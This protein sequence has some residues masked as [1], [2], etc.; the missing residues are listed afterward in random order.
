[1]SVGFKVTEQSYTSQVA[2]KTQNFAISLLDVSKVGK[3]VVKRKIK[4]LQLYSCGNWVYLPY[5]SVITMCFNAYNFS[6]L[7]D[8]NYYNF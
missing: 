5:F 2:V 3:K 8:S 4:F 1:M 6:G 7:F